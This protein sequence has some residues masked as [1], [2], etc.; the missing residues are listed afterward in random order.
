MSLS[1]IYESVQDKLVF[2]TLLRKGTRHQCQNRLQKVAASLYFPK[3]SS[4][5][6]FLKM[7]FGVNR[8]FYAESDISQELN[9]GWFSSVIHMYDCNGLWIFLG[10]SNS[11]TSSS[12][13]ELLKFEGSFDSETLYSLKL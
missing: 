1:L 10:N 12:S 8:F 2:D 13:F 11:S 4:V 5:I 3:S 9:R 6:S 7:R